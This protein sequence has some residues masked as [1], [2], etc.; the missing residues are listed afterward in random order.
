[1][2]TAV[3]LKMKDYRHKEGKS[4][5]YANKDNTDKDFAQMKEQP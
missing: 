4:T 2:A 5:V 1:M 3:H